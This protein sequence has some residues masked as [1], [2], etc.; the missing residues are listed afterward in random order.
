VPIKLIGRDYILAELEDVTVA[1]K[2]SGE[3][4]FPGAK[5]YVLLSYLTGEWLAT[6]YLPADADPKTFDIYCPPQANESMAILC[7][8]LDRTYPADIFDYVS[9]CPTEYGHSEVYDSLI[10]PKLLVSKFFGTKRQGTFANFDYTFTQQNLLHANPTIKS[11]ARGAD[12]DAE[13]KDVSDITIPR[14]SFVGLHEG[15]VVNDDD[16]ALKFNQDVVAPDTIVYP[17]G[18]DI[19]PGY[20]CLSHIGYPHDDTEPNL[21]EFVSGNRLQG[22]SPRARHPYARNHWGQKLLGPVSEFDRL[23]T[24]TTLAPSSLKSIVISGINTSQENIN[25]DFALVFQAR[26]DGST[27]YK[28]EVNWYYNRLR[29]Y[30]GTSYT[31]TYF[32]TYFDT[33]RHIHLVLIP[34]SSGTR[35][36]F[37]TRYY[38]NAKG[39]PASNLG[40][41]LYFLSSEGGQVGDQ[42]FRLGDMYVFDGEIDGGAEVG[43]SVIRSVIVNFVPSEKFNISTAK[44]GRV[45]VPLDEKSTFDLGSQIEYDCFF[46][47]SNHWA[48]ILENHGALQPDTVTRVGRSAINFTGSGAFYGENT[49]DVANN[50]IFCRFRPTHINAGT[51]QVIYKNGDATDGVALAFDANGDFILYG[52]VSGTVTTATIAN[53]YFLDGN[54]YVAKWDGTTLT[55]YD[56]TLDVITSVTE[57]VA[58][59]NG[60]LPESIGGVYDESPASGTASPGE[61]FQGDI[62]DIDVAERGTGDIDFSIEPKIALEL[63]ETGYQL[64]GEVKSFDPSSGFVELFA[65]MPEVVPGVTYQVRS[66]AKHDNKANF[67]FIGWDGSFAASQVWD[68]YF[69]PVD[70]NSPPFTSTITR[71]ASWDNLMAQSLAGALAEEKEIGVPIEEFLGVDYLVAEINPEKIDIA[72]TDMPVKVLLDNSV[73]VNDDF[74]GNDGDF[75]NPKLWIRGKSVSTEAPLLDTYFRI[76]GNELRTTSSSA[77]E[78]SWYSV[79]TAYKLEKVGDI[80]DVQVDYNV[81]GGSTSSIYPLIGL[82]LE[83]GD[84]DTGQYVNARVNKRRWA[85]RNIFS[86]NVIE[87]TTQTADPYYDGNVVPGKLRIRLE[88]SKLSLFIWNGRWEWN[89][90]TSGYVHQIGAGY[91]DVINSPVTVSLDYGMAAGTFDAAFDNF[92]VNVG[93]PIFDSD[94]WKNYCLTTFEGEDNSLADTDFWR[95][96][97]YDNPNYVRLQDNAVRTT[98]TESSG[99][100]YPDIVSLFKLDGEVDFQ[101]DWEVHSWSMPSSNEHR[102]QLYFAWYDSLGER[103]YGYLFISHESGGSKKYKLYVYKDGTQLYTTNYATSDTSGKFKITTSGNTITFF[104]WS[105]GQW[106]WNGNTAGHSYTV[107]SGITQ[108]P[109]YAQYAVYTADAPIDA[110]FSNFIINAGEVVWPTVYEPWVKQEF[111]DQNGVVPVPE[112]I[113]FSESGGTGTT[114]YEIQD[115]K[116]HL[117]V[118]SSEEYNFFLNHNFDLPESFEILVKFDI[119]S[120]NRNRLYFHLKTDIY[121]ILLSRYCHDGAIFKY[122]FGVYDYS[123]AQVGND[124]EFT[125]EEDVAGIRLQ[126][127]NL[128]KTY[129]VYGWNEN[130]EQWEWDGDTKGLSWKDEVSVATERCYFVVKRRGDQQSGSVDV[131]VHNYEV[132]IGRQAPEVLRNSNAPAVFDYLSYFPDKEYR[133]NY[134]KKRIGFCTTQLLN[135]E[136]LDWYKEG[137]RD[138]LSMFVKV[139]EFDPAE[140]TKVYLLFGDEYKQVAESYGSLTGLTGSTEAQAVWNDNFKAV[141]NLYNIVDL[142]FSDNFIEEFTGNDGDYPNPVYWNLAGYLPEI[143]DNQLYF[144]LPVSPEDDYST[145]YFIPPVYRNEEGEFEVEVDFTVVSFTNPSSSN[146]YP[147]ALDVYSEGNKA[148]VGTLVQHVNGNLD[149]FCSNTQGL[150]L[151]AGKNLSTPFNSKLKIKLVGGKLI[152]FVYHNGQWEW[153]GNTSGRELLTLSDTEAPFTIRLQTTADFDGASEVYA[154]NFKIT[155][156]IVYSPSYGMYSDSTSNEIHLT[157]YGSLTDKE[158]GPDGLAFVAD[159]DDYLASDLTDF[160]DIETGYILS[161][162]T[163]WGEYAGDM[164]NLSYIG[165]LNGSPNIGRHDT[166]NYYSLGVGADPMQTNTIINSTTELATVSFDGVDARFR[167]NDNLDPAINPV[168]IADLS[169]VQLFIGGASDGRR[170][171]QTMQHYFLYKDVSNIAAYQKFMTA[172]VKGDLVSFTDVVSFGKELDGW[173]NSKPALFEIISEEAEPVYNFPVYFKIQSAEFIRELKRSHRITGTSLASYKFGFLRDGISD[174]RHPSFATGTGDLKKPKESFSFYPDGDRYGFKLDSSIREVLANTFLTVRLKFYVSA[175]QSQNHILLGSDRKYD[176]I[177]VGLNYNYYRI[178]I[179]SGYGNAS[180]YNTLLSPNYSINA[181]SINTL[182]YSRNLATKHHILWL[183]GYRIAEGD[184][185]YNV[186][187]GTR[188]LYL[189]V[190]DG[191]DLDYHT[192]NV[193]DVGMSKTYIDKG[194]DAKKL[195][196]FDSNF[197]A[198]K[199][200]FSVLSILENFQDFPIHLNDPID[201]IQ[202]QKTENNQSVCVALSCDALT[203]YIFKSSV[204]KAIV[205]KDDTIH[206]NTGVST[207]HYLDS[208]NLWSELD[209]LEN[210]T[211]M[212]LRVP[213]NRMTAAQTV[214]LTDTNLASR[215]NASI[216]QINFVVGL[217]TTRNDE[218]P[219]F[220]SIGVNNK[221]YTLGEVIDLAPYDGVIQGSKITWSYLGNM[222]AVTVYVILTGQ[223]SWTE[224]A[225]NG[226]EIPGITAGMSTTGKKLQVRIVQDLSIESNPTDVGV[227]VQIW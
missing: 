227:D 118:T 166:T 23:N 195:D 59:A 91:I 17:P 31:E 12:L 133:L 142:V 25:T 37:Y 207:W 161:T 189:G 46:P 172:S 111:I 204:W 33:A 77:V 3:E 5:L 52:A 179:Y 129:T 78:G 90:N 16:F 22:Y 154:D 24:G 28:V 177:Q 124:Y 57:T 86:I 51:L 2:I 147:F 160:S 221:K 36:Y 197:V 184:F 76:F 114:T 60:T 201:S 43:E 42:N 18:E 82:F 13:F 127:D 140:I 95:I 32:E 202:I 30:N 103:T 165:L 162:Y 182:V 131:Y 180:Y 150:W 70:V 44:S 216:G 200:D 186:T 113:D 119:N 148:T 81:Y 112:F 128:T 100:E 158:P 192:Q 198:Y 54:V 21:V 47:L 35:I 55:I 106:E 40:E 224:V 187:A 132:L 38:F 222:S 199:Q 145:C 138:L 173:K 108:G 74:T 178:E 26:P 123:W 223:A 203:Y 34:T 10:F 120:S 92:Q 185:S 58:M 213:T 61:Y 62:L 171:N 15:V 156:G 152:G 188:S 80:I 8:D 225:I 56:E 29:I 67:N 136:L 168:T 116:L 107:T 99:I 215:P 87:G 210:A 94:F 143:K 4:T 176:E 39:L 141:Y 50:D 102:V 181:R 149:F 191:Y 170:T 49:V 135:T 68:K 122:H 93:S 214:A 1:N 64:Y 85:N 9:L 208:Q 41:P 130:Q 48:D 117:N 109:L 218:I 139:P 196:L 151:P 212:A 65:A 98:K 104:V 45:S 121:N 159:N 193:W 209:D 69:D 115:N 217:M 83:F 190:P 101:I 146:S 66:Y 88:G 163:A 155:S 97:N 167:L 125:Y 20:T 183:N 75:P 175:F 27:Y 7:H 219:E 220:E 169:N 14:T 174:F 157:P 144:N 73:V 63:G 134:L 53:S 206:G 105:N 89:G 96:R 11:V 79:T 6:Y 126:Y 84:K 72:L 153:N 137:S 205:S 110:S 226:Q 164:W 19:F 194:K 211:M 71:S